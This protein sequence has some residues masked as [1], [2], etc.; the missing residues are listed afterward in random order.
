MLWRMEPILTCNLNGVGSPVPCELLFGSTKT[1]T[2]GRV[3][4]TGTE[5]SSRLE[6]LTSLPKLDGAEKLDK[7]HRSQLPVR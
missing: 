2:M 4:Q 3:F 5:W 7:Q 1:A 6:K